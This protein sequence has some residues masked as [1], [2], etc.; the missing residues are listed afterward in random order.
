[1]FQ[2]NTN[3]RG[4]HQVMLVNTLECTIIMGCYNKWSDNRCSWCHVY[5]LASNTT[6]AMV[7]WMINCFS[8]SDWTTSCISMNSEMKI[9][10]KKL[11]CTCW[12]GVGAMYNTP[13]TRAGLL[14][15]PVHEYHKY[16]WHTYSMRADYTQLEQNTCGYF[17]YRAFTLQCATHLG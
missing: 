7:W 12:I 16:S 13:T 5:V 14:V 1:M 17:E 11:R 9:C 4:Q 8:Q 10:N 15:H 3:T 6:K 2:A